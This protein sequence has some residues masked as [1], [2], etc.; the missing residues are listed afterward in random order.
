MNKI[1]KIKNLSELDNY[2]KTQNTNECN[3]VNYAWFEY[4]FYPIFFNELFKEFFTTLN[5]KYIGVCFEGQ[6]LVY[7]DKV[8]DLL[9]LENFI[10]TK[11]TY[12][13]NKESDLLIHNFKTINDRGIAFWF[14]LRNFDEDD[15][16]Q[17][18]N[19]YKFKNIIHPIGKTIPWDN[20]LFPGLNYKYA[21]GEKNFFTP[22]THWNIYHTLGWDLKYWRKDYT[23][24]N[25][26]NITDYYCIFVK[27]TWKTRKFHSSNI[28]DFLISSGKKG[29]GYISKDFYTNLINYFIENNKKLVIINDLVKYPIPKNENIIEFNMIGF[30]DIEKFCSVV[31]N[32][33]LFLT[34]STS[35]LD[36]ATYYCDTNIVCLDDINT[37]KNNKCNWVNK[38]MKFKNKK[39]IS[40]NMEKG[41]YNDLINFIESI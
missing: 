9:V 33:K 37:E 19:K 7:K 16:H 40:Y 29:S 27:N 21:T 24:K 34:P 41:N 13:N 5:G 17:I 28:K 18:I 39:A 6:E 31:H 14:T 32:S 36:L 2:L 35:P 20:G 8:N 11:K 12:I 30:F 10:N 22:K 38:I 1:I 4:G 15:Y 26:L 3:I 23:F 25:I